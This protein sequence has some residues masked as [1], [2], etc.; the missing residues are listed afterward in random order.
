[1]HQIKLLVRYFFLLASFFI[2]TIKHE[3]MIRH[4]MLCDVVWGMH[5]NFKFSMKRRREMKRR[6]KVRIPKY[7]WY[8]YIHTYM[9]V[10]YI[11]R[12]IH[13]QTTAFSWEILQDTIAHVACWL[14]IRG[15]FLSAL[16]T[17]FYNRNNT[18]I[19]L[20]TLLW[21]PNTEVI[22]ICKLHTLYYGNVD[23]CLTKLALS[24]QTIFC[25]WK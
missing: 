5:K 15:F 8:T 18:N 13:S 22:M 1:M 21:I 3:K 4:T 24:W 17:H 23:G 2:E 12:M 11:L 7:Y 9:H 16:R 25:F 10:K 19:V 14:G 20:K 6:L